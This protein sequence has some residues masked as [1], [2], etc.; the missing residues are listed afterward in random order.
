MVVECTSDVACFD[1]ARERTVLRSLHFAHVFSQFGWD[2]SQVKMSVNGCFI[3]GF[4]GI[5]CCFHAF[6][7]TCLCFGD[8]AELVE[9]QAAVDGS[10]AHGNV[11]LLAAGEVGQ[12]ERLDV[13]WDESNLSVDGAAGLQLLVVVAADGVEHVGV[14]VADRERIIENGRVENQADLRVAGTLDISNPGKVEDG[15]GN[16]LVVGFVHRHH[17]VK[18]ANRVF[19]ASCTSCKGC[20]VYAVQR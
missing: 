16:R 11:V 7:F 5:G 8:Q 3:G 15:V 12:R 1:E 13:A 6:Q 20:P 17:D 4:K 9:P 2:V 18:V 14:D 19:S 10:L